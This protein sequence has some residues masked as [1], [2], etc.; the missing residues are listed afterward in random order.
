MPQS[1]V[2]SLTLRSYFSTL[3]SVTCTSTGTTSERD[4]TT[5]RA[6]A[7]RVFKCILNR[8]WRK[9]LNT[10]YSLEQITYFCPSKYKH[11]NPRFINLY[12]FIQ[13]IMRIL[14]R[15]TL[16]S[17]N[18][19]AQIGRQTSCLTLCT[20]TPTHTHILVQHFYFSNETWRLSIAT[21]VTNRLVPG[22]S[23]I[24]NIERNYNC[25][26]SRLPVNLGMFIIIYVTLNIENN[27]IK[28]NGLDCQWILG[29]IQW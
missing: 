11:W 29:Y 24:N 6:V 9:S 22:F 10:S 3:K 17:I 14:K 18:R 23:N 13:T 19:I 26:L 25:R 12:C 4:N 1:R 16:S 8:I 2:Q 5:E 20:Y 21:S 7:Y 15:F 27:I 28:H